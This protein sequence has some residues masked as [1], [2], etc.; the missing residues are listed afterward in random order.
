MKLII[1]LIIINLVGSFKI[2][3][4]ILSVTNLA[5]TKI[6]TD[7]LKQLDIEKNISRKI[8]HITSAPTFIYTWQFYDS[9]LWASFVPALMLLLLITKNKDLSKVISRSGDNN[10]LSRGPAFY[11]LILLLVT[12]GYWKNDPIGLIAMNQLAI[13]DGF[14]EIIGRN[15]GKNKWLNSTKSVEGSLA[16]IL[17]SS[18]FTYFSLY[19]FNLFE[20]CYKYSFQEIL[21]ISI[22]CSISELISEIDDNISIPI[23]AI[24]I[25]Y[26]LLTFKYTNLIDQI[27]N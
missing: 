15:F 24:F 16:F 26:L 21:V 9:Q 13:G 2:P 4:P 12:I 25:N 17:S 5:T 23:T 14:A 20:D 11:T 8:I 27:V 1:F 22:C 19:N 10:E 6:L 7:K 3:D 18:F